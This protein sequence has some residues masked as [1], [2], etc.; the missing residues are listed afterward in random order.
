M[1]GDG[2]TGQHGLEILDRTERL[3]DLDS[4]AAS[5]LG[6]CNTGMRTAFRAHILQMLGSLAGVPAIDGD[7]PSMTSKLDIE[8]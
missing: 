7:C 5:K 6:P 3:A 1:K 2:I 8:Y 4:I